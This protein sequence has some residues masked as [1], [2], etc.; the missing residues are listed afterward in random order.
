MRPEPGQL[1]HDPACGTG[2]F[3]LA[4]HDHTYMTKPHVFHSLICALIHNHDGLPGATEATGL[5]PTGAYYTDRESALTSLKRLAVA[6][7]E[8]D[9][10]DFADYVK[11][12]SEGGNR[13]AQRGARVKWL[14]E[15]LRGQFA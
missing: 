14:C 12:A 15:A 6:H 5:I 9:T 4:V 7:E 2:G 11:A 13:A 8:K 1:I 10:T 3:L